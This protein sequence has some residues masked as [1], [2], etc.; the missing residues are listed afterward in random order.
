MNLLKSACRLLLPHWDSDCG[1]VLES[2]QTFFSYIFDLV[3]TS[4]LPEPFTEWVQSEV[5]ENCVLEAPFCSIEPVILT[6]GSIRLIGV[7][8]KHAPLSWVSI[9]NS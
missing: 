7:L 2:V 1:R 4:R 3:F 8:V 6:K 9:K 5:I